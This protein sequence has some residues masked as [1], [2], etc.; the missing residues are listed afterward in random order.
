MRNFYWLVPVILL[1]A[2]A[3]GFD[4]HTCYPRLRDDV[5]HAR[6][7][8]YTGRIDDL[9]ALPNSGQDKGS[10]RTYV[11]AIRA[12]GKGGTCAYV[13]K[14]T[15]DDSC[16]IQNREFTGCCPDSRSDFY[17]PAKSGAV[18]YQMA[19]E[20]CNKLLSLIDGANKSPKSAAAAAAEV[21]GGSSR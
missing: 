2:E 21:V 17:S 19:R 16:N 3:H 4:P 6:G 7:P 9:M 5:A 15:F 10:A 12:Y 18:V 14:L 13:D 8:G 1:A 11:A 20:K